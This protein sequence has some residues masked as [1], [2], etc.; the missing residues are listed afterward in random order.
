METN[1]PGQA[2]ERITLARKV[3]SQEKKRIV[4][5][6]KAESRAEKESY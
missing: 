3:E 1:S 4:L 6:R 5:A 2:K